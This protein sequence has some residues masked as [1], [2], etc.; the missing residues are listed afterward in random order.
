MG[1]RLRSMK[2]LAMRCVFLVIAVV[3]ALP[4]VAE[5]TGKPYFDT[6]PVP[7]FANKVGPFANPSETYRYY[8]LPFCQ[9]RSVVYQ[10]ADLGHV[11]KG[12]R[13]ANSLYDVRFKE[14]RNKVVICHHSLNGE[15]QKQFRNA[16]DEDYYF[17]MVVDE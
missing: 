10:E 17:E 15:A 14:G 4:K 5:G 11:I 9:P 2:I 8:Q 7:I 3:L 13:L 6:E 1:A 12:D 16:I